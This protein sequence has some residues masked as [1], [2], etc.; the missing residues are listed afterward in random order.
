[1][2]VPESQRIIV[3]FIK[4]KIIQSIFRCSQKTNGLQTLQSAATKKL[5]AIPSP[6]L[7][8]LAKRNKAESLC[9]HVLLA[10]N[11]R[12]RFT[13]FFVAPIRAYNNV[14]SPL[15]PHAYR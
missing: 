8:K 5:K 7:Q 1:M 4:L 11:P 13:T 3:C 9:K 2:Y 6:T 14:A 15:N 10:Q 12:F